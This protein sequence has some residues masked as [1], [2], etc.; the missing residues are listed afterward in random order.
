MEG[1]LPSIHSFFPFV[2][3]LFQ[4]RKI[5]TKTYKPYFLPFRFSLHLILEKGNVMV[6]KTG[7]FQSS[8]STGIQ[9]C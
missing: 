8:F 2:F 9:F 3:F 5:S 1:N 7:A 4:A 6:V